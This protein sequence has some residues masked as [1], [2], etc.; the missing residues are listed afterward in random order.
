MKIIIGKCKGAYE[1]ENVSKEF[2][3]TMLAIIRESSLIAQNLAH[4]V[5]PV[6][7]I[8][9]GAKITI[10]PLSTTEIQVIAA[11]GDGQKV[12]LNFHEIISVS[13]VLDV[14]E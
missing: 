2:E 5:R 8:G 12:T 4:G 10:E 1:N 9:G 11:T 3:G 7:Y 14:G 13:N 6:C